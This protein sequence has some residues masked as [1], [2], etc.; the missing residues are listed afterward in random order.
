MSHI[1]FIELRRPALLQYA[2]NITLNGQVFKVLIDTGSS[3]LWYVPEV[4]PSHEVSFNKT[5]IDVVFH[6]GGGDVSGTIGF[7]SVELG[8]YTS[9][10]QS[11]TNR[12][13][14]VGVGQITNVGL[15]GLIGLSFNGVV[16]SNLAE[17]MQKNGSDPNLARPFLYNIFSQTPQQENFIGISLSR[18]DDLEGSADASF[19]INEVDEAYADV[20]NAPILPLL[21]VNMPRWNILVDGI[22]VDGV[23]ISMPTSIAG[24]PDGKL[25]ALM[26][27]GSPSGNLPYDLYTAIY[28]AIPGHEEQDIMLWS[29]P[30]NTTSIVTRQISGQPFPIHPLDLSN[31][32]RD[33]HSNTALICTSAF[34]GFDGEYHDYDILFGDTFMRNVYS[35]FNFGDAISNSPTGNASMQLLSQTNATAAI[36]DVLNVR[37]PRISAQLARNSTT[38]L[39]AA[40]SN[41][42]APSSEVKKY[43]PIVIGL[44]G[45]NLLVGVV[46]LALGLA[47]C[48]KRSGKMG[49]T[50]TG[51]KYQ[52][53]RILGEETR[54]LGEFTDKRYSD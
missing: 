1:R 44:L 40:D 36:A 4:K 23:N 54:G 13:I 48:I 17:T 31:V 15:D 22:D 39:A 29:I 10:N 3:D 25:V 37:M 38:A 7:A 43:A 50:G 12:I 28:T 47:A 21:H 5:G 16:A 51:G 20:V 49:R 30:C 2:T 26:D 14:Q 27:T 6:Y 34:H 8:E 45:A 11:H 18:S 42:S 19:T 46:L 53:V 24:A 52:A 9:D 33:P 32:G 35:V 41:G